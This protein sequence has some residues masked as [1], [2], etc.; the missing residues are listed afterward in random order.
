MQ[1]EPF[2]DPPP[3]APVLRTEV[4]GPESRRIYAAEEELQ[5]GGTSAGSQWSRLAVIDGKGAIVRDVDGNFLLDACSGTVV[6]NVG[7]GNHAIAEALC[8]QAQRI[9]H[10]YDFAAPVR[11]EFLA[12]LKATLPERLNTFSLHNSGAE[13]VEAALRVVRSATG[14]QEIIA[15]HNAFHG[16]SMGAL[17]LTS[18]SGRKG[19]GP[20]LP[21]VYHA[22]APYKAGCP[23]KDA[24]ESLVPSCISQLELLADQILPGP[25]AAV[26]IEPVQGAGGVIPMPHEFLAFLRHFCD[27]T[28]ALL[29]FD[30]ILT[31][32][33]RT[34]SMWAFEHSGVVPDI[35]LSGKGI[36]AGFP[37][38]L[39]AGPRDVMSAGPIALPTHN[40]STFGGGQLACAIGLESLRLLLDGELIKNAAVVG[41]HLLRRLRDLLDGSPWVADVRGLGLL[42]GIELSA[43][44]LAADGTEPLPQ[45]LLAAL[46]SRGVVISSSGPVVRITPP[47]CLTLEQADIIANSFAAAL[48]EATGWERRA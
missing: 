40:S 21:G 32:A 27:R 4:P 47:L 25:P 19:V 43:N 37:L 44:A 45:K 34:G 23:T 41:A 10:F 35:L 22:P 31:G 2:P 14:R 36:G 17:S 15:F 24:S 20:L 16:R 39:L 28:G 46:L 12:A 30:E 18:G 5:A 33:G 11:V 42:I 1:Y 8:R 7:H 38:G 26:F 9:T 6:M 3:V 13:A 29:V 48:S